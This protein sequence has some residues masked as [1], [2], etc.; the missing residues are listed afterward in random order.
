MCSTKG[1]DELEANIQN[2]SRELEA[3]MQDNLGLNADDRTHSA[4]AADKRC[5]AGAFEAGKQLKQ[6]D[7][8]D[9]G[10]NSTTTS[11]SHS[12]T[13]SARVVNC[14]SCGGEVRPE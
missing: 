1:Q 14:D 11:T 7:R 13:N 4:S 2:V 6:F 5:S 9:E 10:A 8:K 12:S 3:L